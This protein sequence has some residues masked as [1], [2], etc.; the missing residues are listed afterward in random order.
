MCLWLGGGV[1]EGLCLGM[2]GVL[3]SALCQGGLR[4]EI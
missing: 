3:A 4:E 2:E 1:Y